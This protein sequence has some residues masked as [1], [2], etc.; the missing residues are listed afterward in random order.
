MT[1]SDRLLLKDLSKENRGH[2]MNK[3]GYSLSRIYINRLKLVDNINQRDIDMSTMLIE[4]SKKYEITETVAQLFVSLG[5]DVNLRDSLKRNCFFYLNPN[6]KCS[7]VKILTENATINT[8]ENTGEN[9]SYLEHIISHASRNVISHILNK[10][11]HVSA[12]V[13]ST[14][15]SRKRICKDLSKR[16]SKYV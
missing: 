16:L 12:N 4:I 15:C 14:Y 6:T 2:D 7:V 11:V 3:N 10:N 8:L 13:V 9:K 1:E 5:V